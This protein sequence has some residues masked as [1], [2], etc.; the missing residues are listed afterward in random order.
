MLNYLLK[1][2]NKE[3]KLWDL[4]KKEKEKILSNSREIRGKVLFF[5]LFFVFISPFYY[6]YLVREKKN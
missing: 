3:E 4:Y 1:N 2:E 6:K 5:V